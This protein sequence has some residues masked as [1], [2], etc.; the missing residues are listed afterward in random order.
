MLEI[1]NKSPH[2]AADFPS[3]AF[4]TALPIHGLC[5]NGQRVTYLPT[6]DKACSSRLVAGLD[7]MGRSGS[8]DRNQLSI[9]LVWPVAARAD[10]LLCTTIVR[11][12]TF[13]E[14]SRI[15]TVRRCETS[16]SMDCMER[17]Q[18]PELQ[19]S[20]QANLLL[21]AGESVTM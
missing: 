21:E 13:A 10:L 19:A 18:P 8:P 14:M 16:Q 4:R 2:T 3:R 20:H 12:L 6:I 9:P 11:H 1:C 7:D 15:R 17:T 5:T